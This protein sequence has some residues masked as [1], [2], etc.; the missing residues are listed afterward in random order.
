[1]SPKEYRGSWDVVMEGPTSSHR[2]KQHRQGRNNSN[3][4]EVQEPTEEDEGSE[5][6]ADYLIRDSTSV[7]NQEPRLQ[8]FEE[9][10]RQ[11]D[12]DAA[13]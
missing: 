8:K 10:G 13:V 3:S 2:D 12:G 4:G 9:D 6:W 7:W 5:G 1:M 11:R